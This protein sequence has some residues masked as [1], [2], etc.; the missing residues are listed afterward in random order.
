MKFHGWDTRLLGALGV[1]VA[2]PQLEFLRAWQACEGGTARFNPLNTTEPVPGSTRYNS[3]GVRNY[4]DANMGIAA[5][6]LTLRLDYYARLRRALNTHGIDS[7]QIAVEAARDVAMWGTNPDCILA[8]LS[9]RR[10]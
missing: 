4:L 10:A 3:A 6:L 9:G 1:P 7:R 8:R 2:T 5:T